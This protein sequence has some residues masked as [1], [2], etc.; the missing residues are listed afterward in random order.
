MATFTLQRFDLVVGLPLSSAFKAQRIVIALVQS[1]V[2]KGHYLLLRLW[3]WILYD[4]LVGSCCSR[5]G[6]GGV[7][8]LPAAD[9][10]L[11]QDSLLIAL[12]SLFPWLV[13]AAHG[14]LGCLACTAQRLVAFRVRLDVVKRNKLITY[15]LVDVLSHLLCSLWVVAVSVHLVVGDVKIYQVTFLQ[16]LQRSVDLAWQHFPQRVWNLLLGR[17]FLGHSSLTC[18]LAPIRWTYRSVTQIACCPRIY[19][20]SMHPFGWL[21]SSHSCS[22]AD[23]RVAS[24]L[25]PRHVCTF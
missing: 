17:L 1:G 19:S 11:C 4:W 6:L 15:A 16:V 8:L 2:A 24:N 5:V 3:E 21:F 7:L 13:K 14:L 22:R 12:R 18:T 23:T 10:S 25:A 9:V 20:L